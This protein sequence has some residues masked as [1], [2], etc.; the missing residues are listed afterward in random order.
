VAL[1]KAGAEID[2]KDS[3]GMLA[4]DLAPD[5]AVRLFHYMVSIKQVPPS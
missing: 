2:K 5:V 3:D 1:L 4:L